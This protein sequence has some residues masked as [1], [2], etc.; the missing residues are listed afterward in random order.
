MASF[1]HSRKHLTYWTRGTRLAG[2]VGYLCF[3]LMS[4]G[5]AFI[6][7]LL[8]ACI[9][10]FLYYVI[11]FVI[12]DRSKLPI[13]PAIC[14]AAGTIYEWARESNAKRAAVLV[15]F[16]QYTMQ[17]GMWSSNSFSILIARTKFYS[18]AG[19]AFP[20]GVLLARSTR[21]FCQ[22]S[23][24]I[25]FVFA[26]SQVHSLVLFTS[27]AIWYKCSLLYF[28]FMIGTLDDGVY[29]KK[30]TLLASQDNSYWMEFALS[31]TSIGNYF[32]VILANF[33]GFFVQK[34]C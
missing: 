3:F 25:L 32:D 22:A 34:V 28:T 20:F 16:S 1:N 14:R 11:L 29:V 2:V 12:L 18:T 26:F 21:G 9:L 24:S 10:P 30:Y 5:E 23:M 27:V 31:A 4:L 13:Q 7:T 15:Y 6:T 33:V 8:L 19:L 17:S